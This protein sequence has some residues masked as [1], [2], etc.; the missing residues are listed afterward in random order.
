MEIGKYLNRVFLGDVMDLLK[1][2]PEKSIDMIYGD[3]DYNVGRKYG[4]KS[5]TRGF[6]EYI[7][8]YIE[9]ARESLRVLKNEGNK[10]NY[11]C[12]KC[13]ISYSD[14]LLYI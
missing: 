10:I 4:T 6:D 9:L 3:P 5:Y 13:N 12:F 8:W 1:D 11:F 2:L 7:E 14:V